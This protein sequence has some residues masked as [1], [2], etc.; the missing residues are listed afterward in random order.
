MIGKTLVWTQY[1]TSGCTSIFTYCDKY[2]NELNYKWWSDVSGSRTIVYNAKYLKYYSNG[3]YLYEIF[4][5]IN[6]TKIFNILLK[7]CNRKIEY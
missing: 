4:G 2:K 6:I 1:W 5:K 3:H 7:K